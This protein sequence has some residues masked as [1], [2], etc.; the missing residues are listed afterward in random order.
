MNLAAALWASAYGPAM[1]RSLARFLY[2]LARPIC[3]SRASDGTASQCVAEN[4]FP[5]Y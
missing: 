3:P 1:V 5:R 2:K 4:N